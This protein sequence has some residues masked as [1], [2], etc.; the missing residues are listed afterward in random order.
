MHYASSPFTFD[1]ART[2]E[3]NEPRTFGK[4]N[5]FWVSIPGDDDW[6][7]WVRDNMSHIRLN[8]TYRVTLSDTAAIH[9]IT[10]DFALD[11]FTGE[12]A[13]KTDYERRWHENHQARWPIDWRQVAKDC[14]G[15]IIAPYQW[16]RRM[17]LDW[18]Y[19]WDC[20]S[21]CIWNLSAIASVELVG[22]EAVA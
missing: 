1:P 11:A 4:P 18:Y 15:I 21:G 16:S 17:S 12:F 13:V 9:Y 2:Y 7:T 20:A 22:A 14:D 5:G 6:P 19:G 8:H 3:Q 10:N